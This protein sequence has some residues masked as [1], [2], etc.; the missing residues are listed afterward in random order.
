MRIYSRPEAVSGALT[1]VH[2]L[3]SRKIPNCEEKSEEKL[4]RF[5]TNKVVAGLAGADD[6][7]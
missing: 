7:P 6:P 4:D 2:C 5:A 3:Y 1:V